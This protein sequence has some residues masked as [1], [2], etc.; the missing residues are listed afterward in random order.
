MPL[1]LTVIILFSSATSE[2]MVMVTTK[3]RKLMSFKWKEKLK[4]G[5]PIIRSFINEDEFHRLL[6]LFVW[7]P[8]TTWLLLDENLK[9]QTKL[10]YKDFFPFP[11]FPRVMN[12]YLK[13]HWHHSFCT[14]YCTL[15]LY[16]PTTYVIIYYTQ[17]SLDYILFILSST[18]FIYLEIR[19]VYLIFINRYW[20]LPGS[21][22]LIHNENKFRRY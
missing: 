3:S 20:W 21:I 12:I 6:C 9:L 18:V 17:S 1:Y 8:C 4:Q 15:Q 10:M 19:I 7:R 16:S 11:K 5:P 14:S 22:R 2:G 13:P